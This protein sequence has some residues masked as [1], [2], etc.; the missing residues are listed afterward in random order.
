VSGV[1]D[2]HVQDVR[3]RATAAIKDILKP[4]AVPVPSAASV[5]QLKLLG[6]IAEKVAANADATEAIL[7]TLL[8]IRADM[9]TPAREVTLAERSALTSQ[10]VH[11]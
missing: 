6:L 11:P 5:A 10:E 1:R 3:N 9:P 2:N 7:E 4:D 8:A